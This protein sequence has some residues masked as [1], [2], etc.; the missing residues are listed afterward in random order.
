MCLF[1]PSNDIWA[2]FLSLQ[3]PHGW[4]PGLVIFFDLARPNVCH[5]TE[6]PQARQSQDP[7]THPNSSSGHLGGTSIISFFQIRRFH[8]DPNLLSRAR[9]GVDAGYRY[10]TRGAMRG[11]SY[12]G[13]PT[14]QCHMTCEHSFVT[15][16]LTTIAVSP[17]TSMA[18]TYD[19][20]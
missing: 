17:G 7:K 20:M 13:D 18:G 5:M 15:F 12:P 10:R 9:C 1:T 2:S 11:S 4:G 8:C 19:R 6:C 3:L 16:F 14:A